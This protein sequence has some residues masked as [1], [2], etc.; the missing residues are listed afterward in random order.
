MPDFDSDSDNGDD[1]ED[2]VNHYDEM[3]SYHSY[4]T[5]EVQKYSNEPPCSYDCIRRPS[6]ST[7][8]TGSPTEPTYRMDICRAFAFKLS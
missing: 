2:D 8:S 7:V 6:P 1:Y 3:D 4:S 5:C